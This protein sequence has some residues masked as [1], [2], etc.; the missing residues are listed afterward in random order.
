VN[1]RFSIGSE[2]VVRT[3][4]NK[5]G[6]VVEAGRNG[7]YRVQVEGVTTACRDDDLVAPPEARQKHKKPRGHARLQHPGGR[8]DAEAASPGR[9]D[10][11]G[12]PVEAA[13]ERM[14]AEIDRSLQR[15]ADRLEIVHGKGS[16]RIKDAIHKRLAALSVIARFRLDPHNAG[17]TWAYF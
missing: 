16:G 8:A 17:V 13:I 1:E 14:M 12:L 3:L 10:L 15:G 2:V 11:H 7:R 9:V 6:V 4:G 5:R